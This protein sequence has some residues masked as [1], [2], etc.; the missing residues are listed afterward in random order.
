MRKVLLPIND[1]RRHLAAVSLDLQDA[2]ARVVDSGWLIL[3]HEVELFEQEFASYCGTDFALG[4]ANGT[5]AIEIGLRALGVDKGT[6]VATVAN[7]GFYTTAA[8][9]AIGAEPVY[10]DVSA[11]TYLMDI[12]HLEAVLQD[13]KIETI[14]VT[15]L[16]GHMHEMSAIMAL[17]VRNECKVL[18]DCAQAHGAR[19][20]SRRA[21]SFGDAASFSFYPTKNLGALGDGGAITTSR[22]DVARCVAQ[23]RQYGWDGKYRV[24]AA[25]G[26]NSRL[27]ELQ[28]AV[29]RVKL[30]L[31]DGWN[32]RRREIAAH[33]T[34]H[35]AHPRVQTPREPSAAHV[36]HLYVVRSEN[37]D[38]L[39][40]HLKSEGIAADVHYPIADTLQPIWERQKIW[41]VLPVTELLA[42]EVLSLPCFP[43]MT[44][45]E[46]TNVT[47]AVNRW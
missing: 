25:G 8:L 41:P 17:A 29:L 10:V 4:V 5:E 30:P 28:A 22:L 34:K 32:N 11:D 14:V 1:L 45:E 26:R 35:I 19:Q 46:V 23:L 36:A 12:G 7:A 16:Y 6:R 27:D 24:V 37:R 38:G 31:L 15:H 9:Q 44:D 43:E 2:I 21:G 18:E 33:Y 13:R 20:G 42:S 39:R 3:G 40:D 47:E